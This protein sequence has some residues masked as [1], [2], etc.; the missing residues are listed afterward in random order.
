M[1]IVLTGCQCLRENTFTGRL[2]ETEEFR[3]FRGPDTNAPITV[4]SVRDGDAFLVAYRELRD[5]ADRERSRT[6]LLRNDV[7]LAP[8]TKPLFTTTRV[9]GLKAISLP[10]AP[11][12]PRATVNSNVV[13]IQ[14]EDGSVRE[15][16]LPEYESA[17][18]TTTKAA[19]TPLTIVGDAALVSL[20]AAVIAA[21]AYAHGGGGTFESD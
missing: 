2:W 20:I 5:S 17:S 13:V 11:S 3:H 21:I 7:R 4:Y 14:L 12:L 18:G 8:N 6:L 9:E 19:L 1:L 10:G 15:H 16:V